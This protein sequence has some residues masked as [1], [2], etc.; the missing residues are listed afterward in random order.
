M[1]APS[2]GEFEE[3][4]LLMVA[5]QHDEA[6]GVGYSGRLG[7]EARQKAQHQCRARSLEAHGRQGLCD[8]PL[9]GHHRRAGRSPEE[10]LHRDRAGQTDA[11]PAVRVAGGYLPADS[12][13]FVRVIFSSA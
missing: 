11:G 7:R 13:Y 8:L 3:L 12:Q 9:R 1:K 2:L 5:A 6:Y 10:V 4:V